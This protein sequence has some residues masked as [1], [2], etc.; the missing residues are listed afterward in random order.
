MIKKTNYDEKKTFI[1]YGGVDNNANDWRVDAGKGAIGSP[2]PASVTIPPSPIPTPSPSS[3][4]TVIINGKPLALEQP[5]IIENG[6]TLVPLRAIFEALGAEVDWNPETQ[7]VT[8]GKGGTT[9]MLTIGSNTLIKNGQQ[10]SLDVPARIV[11]GR[12]LVPVR[13]VAESFDAEV[14]WDASTRTVNITG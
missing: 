2:P 4:I 6:R 9:V 1:M 14:E 3:Q 12:T 10:I 8:A 5:P 7:T 11:G 13:A